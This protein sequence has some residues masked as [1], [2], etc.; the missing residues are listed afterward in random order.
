MRKIL[1]TSCLAIVVLFGFMALTCDEDCPVCPKEP[2][3]GSYNVYLADDNQ[4]DTAYIWVVDSFTDS[5]IDS[6]DTPDKYI[7]KMDVSTDGKYLAALASGAMLIFDLEIKEVVY[8]PPVSGYPLFVPNSHQLVLSGFGNENPKILD[9]EAGTILRQDSLQLRIF[10]LSRQ[11][12]HGYGLIG[13]LD[14]VEYCVYDYATMNLVKRHKIRRSDGSRFPVANMTVS[15]DE[16]SIFLIAGPHKVFKYDIRSDSIVDSIF[17]Y[18]GGYFGDLECTADGRYLLV[19]EV[20]QW[21]AFPIGSLTIVSLDSFQAM[22]RLATFGFNPLYPYAPSEL[23]DIAIT[24]DS[25]KAYS[26]PSGFR[27][28]VPVAFNLTKFTAQGLSGLPLGNHVE[29]VA[30]GRKIK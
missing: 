27:G 18:P 20:T 24:P 4:D 5:L 7:T 13:N 2:E 10:A 17:I 25:Y 28:G 15:A 30:I 19:S 21:P 22:R 14:S 9:V 23:G 12:T 29:T 16:E 6:I 11:L 3:P 8:N 1:R 26:C